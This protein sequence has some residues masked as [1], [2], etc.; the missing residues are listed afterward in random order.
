MTQ[1]TASQIKWYHRLGPG[2][3]TACVV[4]GPGSI[5]TSSNVGAR[6]GY[7]MAW[8]VVVSV[9]F[10]LTYMTMG[11][12]LGVAA[13]RSASSVITERA[14]RW[15]AVMIGLSVFFISAEHHGPEIPMGWDEMRW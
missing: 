12:R 9:V 15:L 3:I 5:L 13:G 14:G 2:L 7:S 8:V 1:S 10:M 6:Q 11:A 4:I